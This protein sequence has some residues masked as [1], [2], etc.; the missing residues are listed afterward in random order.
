MDG[1]IIRIRPEYGTLPIWRKGPSD[2]IFDNY[3]IN[4]LKISSEL[5][6]EILDWN[7]LFQ[8]TFQSDYPPDSTFHL[9]KII[10]KFDSLGLEICQKMKQELPN[11][12]IEYYSYKLQRYF[13]SGDSIFNG[14]GHE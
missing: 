14:H 13:D 7:R 1:E 2:R 4:R 5:R 11:T 12:R 3:E 8:N 6:N 9:L 10:E